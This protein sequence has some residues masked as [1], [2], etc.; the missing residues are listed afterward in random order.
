MTEA[1]VI[2]NLRID[3]ETYISTQLAIIDYKIDEAV[4]K[5]EWYD[6]LIKDL[7]TERENLIVGDF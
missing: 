7:Y 2:T 5:K 6:N 3:N 4:K 1:G